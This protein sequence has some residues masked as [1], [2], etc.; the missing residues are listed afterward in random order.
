MISVSYRNV[1][2]ILTAVFDKIAILYLYFGGHL[3]ACIFARHGLMADKLLNIE[4]EQNSGAPGSAFRTGWEKLYFPT[5]RHT[6][7]WSDVT[8]IQELLNS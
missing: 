2:E 1:I 6:L 5:F 4:Y 3:K 7:Q 8:A